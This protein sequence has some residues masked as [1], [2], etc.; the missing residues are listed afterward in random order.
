MKWFRSNV[1]GAGL[2][3]YGNS[4][5]AIACMAIAGFVGWLAFSIFHVLALGVFLSLGALAFLLEALTLASRARRRQLTKLWPEVVDSIYS[6]IVSGLSLSNAIDE[7]GLNGPLR[8]RHSFLRFS[9]R[10]DTG[11]SFDDAID[12]LKSEFG[13]PHADRLCEVL[14]LVSSSGSQSL[15]ASLREQSTNLRSDQAQAG[16]IEAKQ[17]WVSGTAKIA[18]AAPWIVVAMLSTRSENADAYNSASGIAILFLGF[19]ISLFAYRLVHLLSGLP[20]SP[21][22]FQ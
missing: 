19:V 4:T 1:E 22:V 18:V 3:R 14:R 6:A 17:G 13:E 11:W 7:L 16:Q 20:E 5:V 12:E 9:N 10:L 21:R 8:V 2:A 15:A